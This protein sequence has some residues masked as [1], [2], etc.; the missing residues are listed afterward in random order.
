MKNKL[1]GI[2]CFRTINL[3]NR[4]G[5]VLF[6]GRPWSYAFQNN[7]LNAFVFYDSILNS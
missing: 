1:I 6:A 3:V 5:I 4:V 7:E 2:I